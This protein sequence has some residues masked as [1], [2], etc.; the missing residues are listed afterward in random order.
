MPLVML[1]IGTSSTGRPG[2]RSRQSWRETLPWRRLTPL[3]WAARRRARMV[4]QNSS[5]GSLRVL[6][7][8]RDELLPAHSEPA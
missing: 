2:Q 5:F 3:Q 7:A 1:P 6:A 8:E 4:R